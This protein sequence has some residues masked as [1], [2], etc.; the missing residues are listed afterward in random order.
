MLTGIN[1]NNV[2]TYCSPSQMSD[3]K[4]INFI[5]GSNG[6]GKTTISRVLDQ[7]EGHRHCALQWENGTPLKVLVYNSDFIENNFNQENTVKGVFTLGS[8]QVD[9]E[10]QINRLIPQINTLNEEIGR[11]NVQLKG[12]GAEQIGKKAE[13][14]AL[15]PELQEKCWRQKQLHDLYFQEAFTGLRNNAERFKEKVLQQKQINNAD[16]LSL[17]ELKEKATTVFSSNLQ[18]YNSSSF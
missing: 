8:D 18:R 17:D 1:I 9:A 5:F 6:S 10:I 14:E 15:E 13:L 7:V 2:A 11:L 3:F 12:D 16:L 4:K